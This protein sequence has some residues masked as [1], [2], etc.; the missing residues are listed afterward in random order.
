MSSFHCDDDGGSQKGLIC[1]ITPEKYQ[2]RNPKT[3]TKRFHPLDH[4]DYPPHPI[5]SKPYSSITHIPSKCWL[6]SARGEWKVEDFKN[7]NELGE[8]RARIR[9]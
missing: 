5:L 2:R 7:A 6:K 3:H 8:S 1:S 4:P 9:E